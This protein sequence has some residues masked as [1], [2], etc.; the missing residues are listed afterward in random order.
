MTIGHSNRSL[1]ISRYQGHCK[2][3]N[4][5]AKFIWYVYHADMSASCCSTA[6]SQC[7]LHILHGVP[8]KELMHAA[9][10]MHIVYDIRQSAKAF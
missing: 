8:M 6:L 9:Y 3:L 2:C 5:F 4:K 10:G 1:F 7:M